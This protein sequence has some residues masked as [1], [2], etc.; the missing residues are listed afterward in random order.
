MGVA[1]SEIRF[2]HWPLAARG[3][4]RNHTPSGVEH[5][6]D[7]VRVI[8]YLGR[9]DEIALSVFDRTLQHKDLVAKT[10]HFGPGQQDVRFVDAMSDSTL[11]S[12]EV[13]LAATPFAIPARSTG[14]FSLRHREPTPEAL[15]PF[16]VLHG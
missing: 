1:G 11:T 4:R 13:A 3:L 16:P 9:V 2:R 8:K 5:Q 15:S 10:I 14:T 6:S 12:L 7:N